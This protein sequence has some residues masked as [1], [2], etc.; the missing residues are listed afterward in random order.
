MS[1]LGGCFHKKFPLLE[2]KIE[3]KLAP[4]VEEKLAFLIY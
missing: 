2:E 4:L 3:E 1:F